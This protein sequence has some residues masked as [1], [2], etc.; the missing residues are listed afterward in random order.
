MYVQI[1]WSVLFGFIVFGDLPDVF[2]W[3]GAAVVIASGVY[4]AWREY[5]AARRRRAAARFA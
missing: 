2:T 1:V 5:L 3:V 4:L